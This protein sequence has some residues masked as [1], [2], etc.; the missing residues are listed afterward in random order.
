MFY[1]LY[2]IYIYYIYYIFIW[3]I[4][5]LLDQTKVVITIVIKMAK[6]VNK[7]SQWIETKM[8]MVIKAQVVVM[9][10]KHMNVTLIILKNARDYDYRIWTEV[11]G[12]HC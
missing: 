1:K 7:G 9:K 5:V 11:A 3:E 2:I 6:T 8:V 12:K 10:V 4:N